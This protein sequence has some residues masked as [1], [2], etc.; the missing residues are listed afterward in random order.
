MPLP[1]AQ[2]DH[3]ESGNRLLA[4]MTVATVVCTALIAG[5]CVLGSWWLLPAVMATILLTAIGVTAAL[6]KVMGDEGG[7]ALPAARPAAEPVVTAPAP[8]L[9]PARR[10]TAVPGH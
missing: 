7:D 8:A 6:V 1:A 2:S 9:R 10:A 3:P 4:L 5:F